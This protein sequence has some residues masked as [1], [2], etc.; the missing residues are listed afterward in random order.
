MSMQ[1]SPIPGQIRV[2]D[3]QELEVY[4]VSMSIAMRVFNATQE[5][6]NEEKHALTDQ[7]RRSAREVSANLARGWGNRY[8]Q[9]TFDKYLVEAIGA[10]E[11]AKSWLLFALR[12]RYINKALVESI[13]R[14]YEQLKTELFTLSKDWQD[15]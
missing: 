5:F 6:P 4:Q 11:E 2:V 3:F 12:C 8:S 15:M 9:A 14:E 7:L 1:N 13:M 10:I